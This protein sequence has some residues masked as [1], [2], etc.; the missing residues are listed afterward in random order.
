MLKE[1]YDNIDYKSI[2]FLLSLKNIP[3]RTLSESAKKISIEKNKKTCKERYGVENVSQLDE[4]KKKKEKTFT[5]HYGVDNIWK[6]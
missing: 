6:L 1:K 4:I 3:L 2:F 5:E